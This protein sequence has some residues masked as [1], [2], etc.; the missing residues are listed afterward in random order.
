[1]HMRA[2]TRPRRETLRA[3]T[4]R[5]HGA[6]HTGTQH[7]R[8]VQ[9]RWRRRHSEWRPSCHCRRAA[10]EVRPRGAHRADNRRLWPPPPV[11]ARGNQATPSTAQ[12]WCT[13][14]RGKGVRW[15]ARARQAARLRAGGAG[16]ASR[17][18]FLAQ[19]WAP[20]PT[21][22]TH[23]AR[24]VVQACH[25]PRAARRSH[26]PAP[27]APPP[28]PGARCAA[29]PTN[30]NRRFSLRPTSCVPLGQKEGRE[31]NRN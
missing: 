25:T 15:I 1:M 3:A 7:N 9:G 2:C 20:G 21:W 12:L 31:R 8:R 30:C 27:G 19:K 17:R 26:R 6:G 24:S 16:A 29:W 22:I 23:T 4:S 10:C 11:L 5:R 28:P 18:A 14:R 13:A